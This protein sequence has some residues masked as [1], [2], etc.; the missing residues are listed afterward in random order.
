MAD[1]MKVFAP[2]A[3]MQR[4]ALNSKP[5]TPLL[6]F[7][8]AIHLAH[9][10]QVGDSCAARACAASIWKSLSLPCAAKRIISTVASL[11]P[12]HW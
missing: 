12:C 8:C 5:I 6:K 4:H 3:G 11:S 2:T 7:C 10:N 9:F 1:S